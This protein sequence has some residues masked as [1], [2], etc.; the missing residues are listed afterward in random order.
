MYTKYIKKKLETII[1]YECTENEWTPCYNFMW[2]KK[3]MQMICVSNPVI[4]N[5]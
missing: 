2:Q 5:N 3:N 1:F 4:I